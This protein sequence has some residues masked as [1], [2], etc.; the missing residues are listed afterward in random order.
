M[1]EVGF[2]KFSVRLRLSR[3]HFFLLLFS[4][5]LLPLFVTS[6]AA[7]LHPEVV[8]WVAFLSSS[9]CGCCLF[10]LLKQWE[11]RMRASVEQLVKKKCNLVGQL[12]DVAEWQRGYEHQI[13]LLQSSVVKSRAQVNALNLEMENKLVEMRRAY[14]EFEDLRRDSRRLEEEHRL[15]KRETEEQFGQKETMLGEYQRTIQEQRAI[16]EKK[17]TYVTQL[18]SKVRD[19]MYEI[20]VLLQLE[21]SVT[22][23]LPPMDMLNREEVHEYYLG[24]QMPSF[25][26]DLQLSR[27]V[28]KAEQFTGAEH[29]GYL[30]GKGPRFWNGSQSYAIDLRRLF[31][32]LREETTGVIIFYSPTEKKILFANN[33]VKTLL[34]YS[35]E[36]FV[37]DFPLIVKAGYRLW[38]EALEKI[39]ST[40]RLPLILV[41]KK[42]EELK[43]KCEMRVVI[44]GP[45]AGHVMGLISE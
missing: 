16:I 45:F 15:F 38:Q 9:L 31:D 39:E 3:N 4:S 2:R 44:K 23:A 1:A 7:L 36:K 34:G 11:R 18:E 22:N 40:K 35:P 6:G 42:G 28:D 43:L 21:E 19:L 12:P 8:L 10:F 24:N 33:Y 30:N 41:T 13:D 37:N 14:L 20:R 17:Q 32:L 25:D 5:F 26:I 29:L 27:Y